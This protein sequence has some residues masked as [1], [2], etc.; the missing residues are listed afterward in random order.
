MAK[1]VVELCKI[2]EYCEYGEV[3]SDMAGGKAFSKLD[4]SHAYLQVNRKSPATVPG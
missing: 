1:F 2:A 4:L 3:L